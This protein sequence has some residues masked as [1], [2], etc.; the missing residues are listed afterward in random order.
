MDNNINFEKDSDFTN[1]KTS[2]INTDNNV[3]LLQN[4]DNDLQSLNISGKDTP[5]LTSGK[6]HV[7]KVKVKVRPNLTR[8]SDKSSPKKIPMDNLDLLSNPKRNLDKDYSDEASNASSRDFE[9]E[10]SEVD[11]NSLNNDTIFDFNS[12]TDFLNNNKNGTNSVHEENSIHE[13]RIGDENDEDDDDEEYES[14]EYDEEDED[15]GREK[16]YEEIQEEKHKLL[17]YLDRLHNAGYKCSKRYTMASNLEDLK[18]EYQKLKRQRDIEK[19]IKFSRK[20]LMALVSGIEYL[21]G[22]FDPFDIKLSGWSENVMEGITDY[23]EVFEELHDKYSES[24]SVSPELKLLMMVAGS[25]FMFH[26]THSLFKTASPSLDEI[27]K[28]NPDIMRNIQ[29]AAAQNMGSKL[30]PEDDMV[31]NM[32]RQGINM[33]VNQDQKNAFPSPSMPKRQTSSIDDIVNE[34][35]NNSSDVESENGRSVRRIKKKKNKGITLD[36]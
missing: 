6:L 34:L 8:S 1:V 7:N 24:V 12:P 31:A 32:M 15:D 10:E 21:N 9:E 36:L 3:I 11:H 26:L 29:Q 18:F 35:S 14:D 27:L 25:G 13:E 20:I 30:G 33:K 19:S 28:N 23:D 16:T 17:L 4:N 22:R 2:D 5:S